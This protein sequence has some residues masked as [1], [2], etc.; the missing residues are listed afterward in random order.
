MILFI[1]SN[2]QEETTI[3]HYQRNWQTDTIH[4]PCQAWDSRDLLIVFPDS[5]CTNGTVSVK[6][7]K[8][9]NK[10]G[11]GYQLTFAQHVVT[12][13]TITSSRKKQK[14]QLTAYRDNLANKLQN[15]VC[16][17]TATL[18]TKGRRSQLKL[19]ITP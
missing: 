9:I 6:K 1:Y 19:S 2:A 11:Y 16:E 17:Y 18:Q 12:Q 8:W 15:G 10:R 14:K 7:L 5:T 13:V 4:V 3:T